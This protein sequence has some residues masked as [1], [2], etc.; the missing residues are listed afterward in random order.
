MLFSG[1]IGTYL[2]NLLKRIRFQELGCEVEI[3]IRTEKEAAWLRQYQPE[4]KVKFCPHWIYGFKE[5]FF[6]RENIKGGAFWAPHYNIPWDGYEKL[7]VTLHDA[8]LP[9]TPHVP[10]IYNLY[11]RVMYARIQK[12]ANALIAVSEF[13]RHMTQERGRIFGIPIYVTPLGV[14]PTWFTSQMGERV[15]RFPYIIYIGN[16]K[17]HKNLIRLLKAFEQVD[18]EYK[19]VCVGAFKNL[20]SR[21]ESARREMRKMADRVVFA[22][23]VIGEPLRQLVKH[24]S[25]LVLPSTYE[26]FGLPPL[27][28]MA[29]RVPA[30]VSWAEP[31]PEVCGEAALYCDPYSVKSIAEGLQK[32]ISLKGEERE[33]LIEKGVEHAAKYNWDK[34]AAQT[35]DVFK[36]TL[37]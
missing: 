4:S 13:A 5:Q 25:G 36:R 16:L 31:M 35:F 37:L 23:E 15:Y 9:L 29:A 33:S 10:L 7:I 17:K 30:L 28:A 21:D 14:D 20:K 2:K 19:L 8:A 34:T 11:A 32:L 6:W 18:P 26:G 27:E 1:G 12:K 24:S 3:Y 22:D